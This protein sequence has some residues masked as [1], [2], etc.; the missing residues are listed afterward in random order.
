MSL[1]TFTFALLAHLSKGVQRRLWLW[2]LVATEASRPHP[3]RCNL[4]ASNGPRLSASYGF[5]RANQ[6]LRACLALALPTLLFPASSQALSPTPSIRAE[7]VVLDRQDDASVE[8]AQQMPVV[9]SATPAQAGTLTFTFTDDGSTTT[10]TA[11]G[12]LDLSAFTYDPFDNVAGI[13]GILLNNDLNIWSIEPPHSNAARRYNAVNLSTTGSDSYTGKSNLSL[14]GRNYSSDFHIRFRVGGTYY[15]RL[16]AGRFN[17]DVYQV[18]NATATF[19]GTLLDTLG[20]N[21]FHVEH[22]FGSQ[23]IV[24]KATPPQPTAPTGL[25]ATAGDGTVTLNWTD[26]SNDTISKYQLR[27]GQ[28]ATVPDSAAWGDI[29]GSGAT[30]T[31][32][33]VT[34]LTNGQQYAFQIRAVNNGGDGDASATATATPEPDTTPGFGTGTIADQTY[35]QNAAIATLT[36]PE[37]TG[38]NGTLTYS[39][40]PTAPA[41]LAFDATNRTLTGTP[42]AVQSA[43]AYTYTVTDGDGDTATLAFNIT[44]EAPRT[45]TFT[46]SD[47][48]TTTTIAASGSLNMS[49]FRE[50]GDTVP[51][52]IIYIKIDDTEDWAFHPSSLNSTPS[53]R[54]DQLP[55]FNMTGKDSFDGNTEVAGLSNYS[56]DFTIRFNTFR[57]YMIVDKASLTGDIYDPTGKDVT[58]SGTLLSTVGDN[59]FDIELAVGNQK[60]IYKTATPATVPAAPTD[61]EAA[62][63]DTQVDLT[64][65]KPSNSTITK[66]QLRHK[67]GTSFS[68]GDDSLWTDIASSGASTTSHTVTGLTNGTEYAFEIRAVN[69][70]GNSSASS[71]VT[72][73]PTLAVPAAP[74]GLGA[75]AGATK[76]TLM[77]TNPQNTSITK[78]QLRYGAGTTVPAS[79]TWGDIADSGATTT[80]HE[81]TGLTNGTQY[82]FEIRA[83]N[84]TGNSDASATVTAT[85]TVPR[86]LT[87]IFSDDG[88]TVTVDASGS[89]DVSGFNLRSTTN[90]NA[91]AVIKMGDLSDWTLFPSSRLAI[92]IYNNLPKISTTGESSY[93]EGKSEVE[94]LAS[95][96][97]GFH[98]ALDT[99]PQFADLELNSSH[100]SENNIYSLD[101]DITFTGT[102]LTTLEDND[103][104]IEHA[105]GNQKI[106]YTTTPPPAPAA[107]T[108]LSAAA[109][110]TQATLSWTDSN[111]P[112]ITKYQLR[113]GAGSTVPA[114]ATWEDITGSGVGTTSHVVTGLTN[115]TQYAFEI[116]TVNAGGDSDASSTATA[117]PALAA[118]AAPTDLSATAGNAQ[119]ALSWTLPTNASVIGDV[120]VR[121]KA[122]ADL[123]FNDASDTWTDLSDGTATTYTATGLTNGTGYTFEVRATNT[124][125]DGAAATATATPALPIAPSAPTGLA[126]TADDTKV[127][128]AWT[129]PQ[130]STIT[131]YQLRYGATEPDSVT[132]P[133]TATWGDIADSG[134]TTTSHVVTGLTNGTEYA[135]E[136]R[137]VNATGDSDASATVTATPSQ[138]RTLTYTFSDNGGT[139]TIAASGSLDV[140]GFT[141]DEEGTPTDYTNIRMDDTDIWGIHPPGEIKIYRYNSLPNF[142]ATGEDTYDG[143][144]ELAGMSNYSSNFHIRFSTWD[145]QLQLDKANFT[146]NIYQISNGVATFS[147]TLAD[148]LGD[149]DFHIEHAIG[150][151]KIIFTATPS[152]TAPDAPTGLAAAAGD[153]EVTLSWD[154]PSNSTI[155]KYQLRHKAGTSFSDGDDSLWTDIAGSGA[156]TTSHTVSGLTNGT[157]YAFEIRA[158]NAGGTGPA[159]EQVVMR[160]GPPLQPSGF[161]VVGGN[162]QVTLSWSD[163]PSDT[164]ITKYQ[165]RHKV[166][167][168]FSDSDTWSDMANSGPTTTTHAVSGLTNGTTWA[169]QI[170]ALNAGG[171]G[172]ASETLTML[173][174]ANNR[175]PVFQG[176]VFGNNG[177]VLPSRYRNTRLTKGFSPAFSDPDGDELTFTWT[178]N[179]PQANLDV[180]ITEPGF[181]T[182]NP[183]SQ[184]LR[185]RATGPVERTTLTLTGTD[186]YGLSASTSAVVTTSNTAPKAKSPPYPDQTLA[187]GNT[188]TVNMTDMFVDDEGDNISLFLRTP[189]SGKNVDT[190]AAD[191]S[192]FSVIAHTPGEEVISVSV[193]DLFG[194][195]GSDSFKVTVIAAA[196][197]PAGL[198]ATSGDEQ[199]VLTWINPGDSGITKYQVRHKA[200]TSFSE[201]DDGLWTDITGSGASTTSHTVTGLTSG[202]AYVFQVRA[203]NAGGVGT[204]S[205]EA[206]L[207]L[208]A[209]LQPSGF[210]VLGGNAE[211]TL[212]WSD[213]SDA[214][215]TRYQLRRKVGTSFSPSDDSLWTDMANSGAATTTHTVS[216]LT[217]NTTWAFQVRAVNANGAG[218]ASETLTMLPR[219]NN[220]APVLGGS[221]F[222][223]DG[224]VLPSRYRN[225][226]LTKGFGPRFLDPDGDEL[227]FTWTA[228]PPQ[229]NLDVLIAEPGYSDAYPD[230]HYLRYRATGPVERTTL[231]LTGTDPYGLSV[232]TSAVVTTSNTAP[233]AK[234][235]PYPDQILAVGNTL[236][237]KLTDMFV[238]EDGDNIRSYLRTPSRGESI[239]TLAVDSGFS[240]TAHT[241]GEDDITITVTDI[242]NAQ[243]SDSFKVTVI[244]AA[245]K[246]TGFTATSGDEQAVLAWT[247]PGDSSITKYQLRHK[248]G[249]SFSDSDD[250]LWADIDGSGAGTT[251][252]TVTEL[253]NGT[254]YVFQ[255]RAVN[256]GGPGAASDTA[257]ATPTLAIPDT[258]PSLSATK[259]D[260]ETTLT[261]TLPS[262]ASQIDKVQVRWKATADMP[263]GASDAWT[264][265]AATAETYTATGLTN[266]TSYTFAVRA[267]NSAGNGAAATTTAT[268]KQ[269]TPTSANFTLEVSKPRERLP[270]SQTSSSSVFSYT[271]SVSSGAAFQAVQIVALPLP[272]TGTLKTIPATRS[273]TAKETDVAAGDKISVI[274]LQDAA[275]A[276]ELAFFPPD[277][278]TNFKT[279]FTFKV[280]DTGDVVS[281]ETYTATLDFKGTTTNSRPQLNIPTVAKQVFTAGRAVD[282]P[283]L[284]SNTGNGKLKYTMTPA[285]PTGLVYDGDGPDNE[286]VERGHAN[287]PRFTG[288]PMQVTEEKE[289]TLTVSDTDNE[290]GEADEDTV[291]FKIEVV[292]STPPTASNN[293][294]TTDED[295]AYTFDAADFNFSDKDTGDTFA[296]VKITSLATAGTLQLSDADVIQDQEITVADIDADKLTFTPAANEN[297]TDYATFQFTV[298]DS[299]VDSE[300]SY[301]MTIDVTA[302]NDAPT[303]ASGIPDRTAT[304]GS[305]FSYTFPANTFV[306]V[307]GDTL[308][309]TA[310]QSDDSALPSWLS[311]DEATRTFS[312]TPQ[313]ADVDTVTTVKVTASDG[314]DAEISDE[315]DVTVK[316]TPNT[317][318]TATDSMVTTDEDTTYAFKA[319]DFNFSDV[320][321]GDVLSSV[322]VTVL[323][324]AGALKLNGADVT[325]GQVIAKAALDAGNLAFTPAAHENGTGYATFKFTVNDGAADS[326]SSYTMTINVTAVNDVPTAS[327]KTVTTHEDTTYTFA[328]ADFSFSDVDT[329]NTFAS[330]KITELESA[331]SLQLNGADVIL[332]QVIVVADITANN[333]TFTP[334][335]NANGA[336]YSIFKFTV[337]DGTTD[338]ALSY[339]M[340]INVTAVSDAPTAENNTVTTNEDTAYTFAVADFNY[341]DVDTGQTLASVKITELETA[342]ALQLD[343]ADVTLNQ[344]IIA[345]DIEADKLTFT[346]AV[347]ANGDPYAT[348][349]FT[350]NDGTADSVLPYTMTIDVTAVNDV[351]TASDNTV[352]TDEDTTHTF[353]VADFNYNDVETGDAL[354]SVKIT[355]LETAGALQLSGADVTLD[356]VIAAADIGEE[357]LTFAPAA[358]A[359][360]APYATFK[361][362]VNDGAA[363]SALPYTMTINVTA[364]NDAPTAEDNKV[365]TDEDKTYTFDAADFKFRD[366]D[367]GQTLTSVT[368]T[369]LE[370]AGALQLSGAGVTQDQVITAADIEADKLTFTPASNANG[371]PYATFNFTVNDGTVDSA[372][373]YTMTI[374]VTA[375]NDAPT[376]VNGIP[377]RTA[378]VGSAF[379]YAFPKNTFADADDT[380]TYTATQANGDPLPSWMGFTAA[381]RLFSGTPATA[382]LGTVSVKVTANDGNGGEISDEFDVTVRATPNTP[383][384]AQDSMVTTDE[385]TAYV[386]KASDFNFS[387]NDTGDVL[388]S[389]KVTALQSAAGVLKLNGVDVTE[390]RVIAKDALDSGHLTFTPAA[391]ENGTGYATFQF[392]VND[393]EA[394]SASSYT[395]K[396]DV[397]AVNDAPAAAD[398]TVT[399]NEGTAYTFAVADFSFSDDDTGDALASVKITELESAGS[400]QLNDEDVTLDQVIEVADIIAS[401]LTF[402]PAANANGTNYATFKFTVNDGAVD[403]ASSYTMTINVTAVND[404]PT[405]ENNTVTTDE[406]KTY[407]FD[408]ADFKFSDVDTGGVLASVKITGLATAGALQLGNE[409]VTLDQV[410]AVADIT[411]GN[412]KFT[413]ESDANGDPYATFK[414]TVN[415][416]T[417]DSVSSY[418][419]TI[420]VTAVNDVPTVAN[421]IPDQPATVAGAFRYTFPEKTFADADGD[422]LTYTATQANGDPLPSWMG[423]TAA[424]R[425]FL[426]V[427]QASNLGTVALRVTA[428]DGNGGTVSDDFVVTV[429]DAP[430]VIITA[431]DELTAGETATVTVTF[432]KSVTGFEI[433]EL[434][435]T[436]ATAGTLSKL[437]FPNSGTTY[438]AMLTLANDAPSTIRLS[439]ASDVAVD[440]ANTGNPGHITQE[441]PIKRTGNVQTPDTTRPT[442]TIKTSD[443]ELTAGETA[444]VT[445][446]FS[447]DVTGFEKGDLTASAGSLSGFTGDGTTYTATLTPPDDDKGTITLSVAAGVAKD[448]AGNVNTAA[449]VVTLSYNTT[450]AMASQESLEKVN[451]V[452]LPDIIHNTVG[453]HV[454]VL[455]AR[456][457]S[458]S[459]LT[460]GRFGSS[461]SMDLEDMTNAI[462]S[463]VFDYGDELANGTVD[464]HQ[465]LDGRSFSFPAAATSNARV[466]KGPEGVMDDPNLGLFSTLSF[467]GRADYSSFSRELD[468]NNLQ[469]DTEGDTFT[470]HIGADVQPTPRLATGLSLA[471]SR[472][473]VDWDGKDGVNGTHTVNFTTVH[474]YVSWFAGNWQVWISGLFGSG[475]AEW[476][477]EEGGVVENS[478]SVSGLA[479]GARYRFWKSAAEEYPPS[480]SLKLD[481]ATASFLGVDAL[482]ARLAIEAD[483]QFPV[484]SGE[485]TGA[486]S[487]GLRIKD[488]STYGTGTAVEVGAGSTWQGERLAVSGQGRLLFGVGEQE[489]REW[490]VSGTV[491]YTPGSDGEGVMVSLEPSI[492]VTSSKQAELWNLTGSDLALGGEQEELE[493]RLRAELAYGLRR[494]T[495]LLTP[496]TELS[497]TPS[498]NIYGIG[499]RYDLG[500]DVMLDLHGSHT[501]PV[502]G[503]GENS[504]EVDLNTQF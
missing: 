334:E 317:P 319:S 404:A 19:T 170:R 379:S 211:V 190:S 193:R 2:V 267:I 271:P 333:L 332:D 254:D 363:D 35:T 164:T 134:A 308:T 500:S 201:G 152:I 455:T 110:D 108:G 47:D 456:F 51:E 374:D 212:S 380:L 34:G 295:T 324:S 192:A 405:A 187:V 174:R 272:G 43:T 114:S 394:D 72:A 496:Y 143:T 321:T 304:V 448:S 27:Y 184:Y 287:A 255:I 387:D 173:P 231:I 126:A 364:V 449:E 76:V 483:R 199:A 349:K 185:Y 486:A 63:G 343:G 384:T 323:E 457:D 407:T 406:D 427:P 123:P 487:L 258:P 501:A 220:R 154:N 504:L 175:A 318:P 44:I 351:P 145:K 41:G 153:T 160:P 490:G 107:P 24:F 129:N 484:W 429:T 206:V 80:S 466:I 465:A 118:P 468:H 353:D 280:I 446:T 442:A 68:D 6:G 217:N 204:P 411:A 4:A 373:S 433:H 299:T 301:T 472:S 268:P 157:Q 309:Y 312:G 75:T 142:V 55:D 130:D 84:A 102:L 277:G 279:T 12:S 146:G 350:V 200:G 439:V 370:T 20:D 195:E 366:V 388:S 156:G 339:T 476:D 97:S 341:S 430:T 218:P 228:N 403:S 224:V 215:I 357:K 52:D 250:S 196:A 408:A 419:M 79:A 90:Q 150:N 447:E 95:Y 83:V 291:T 368:I 420:D 105:I 415:D 168:S 499:V 69:D 473:H 32:H 22:A 494:G 264:D 475:D 497:I 60:I 470:V 241:P 165:L 176:S 246:P 227:T 120:Q 381:T 208:G 163:P 56:N 209:P 3:L 340:T 346:P 498:S 125:G 96:N 298:S 260:T 197:K 101:Q 480:L 141:F 396:I 136:I 462:A 167:T 313:A 451:T 284:W 207:R 180:L 302:V 25:A 305:A 74:T 240:V 489:W 73:T 225:V 294:V 177:V 104:H 269:A 202:T 221:V 140:S 46:F 62:V 5:S 31:S 229:A 100:I 71:T 375:V 316:A 495:V 89:L 435:V 194:A 222:G 139:V 119:A 64:W 266:D 70:R 437:D 77:W 417:A 362:T 116:R 326:A 247:D 178:A 303:M 171:A 376:L 338:S 203:V 410:I 288:M 29:D 242:F 103:F 412:L 453:H 367:T 395:M 310:T 94:N 331:G 262:N 336:P 482:Q 36:L 452:V 147:G 230:S 233:K 471:F 257:T 360:G 234:S 460:L 354:A 330:V 372:A 335:A 428:D 186:P 59:D 61:L 401:N 235:P 238:D 93:N 58:F 390:G 48:G 87:F 179:P 371:D 42:T 67:A 283:F 91:R 289:Y 454:E 252:H 111:D 270:A 66:Y 113:Y 239:S 320:D 352:T 322:K 149:N 213:P 26:P 281:E 109:G 286:G 248:A 377:D 263:F 265:L 124:A 488:D 243:G 188:L 342:G 361:F 191:L 421:T 469:A 30:T 329:G 275:V 106:V 479:G 253:T 166:G 122:T 135:F 99:D 7:K 386:F 183:D 327:D 161:R 445:V 205:D 158:V 219:A 274:S 467:W 402:M 38:G 256:A 397:A 182:V 416:G 503:E 245:A 244:A 359:N 400:L 463:T 314:N 425:T 88:S 85:P 261:W 78:Y 237:V 344:V 138:P 436:P 86:T 45:L 181:S 369:S 151:Q 249:T 418:T 112:T 328:V 358:N 459:P 458:I 348:F 502:R 325:E 9:L 474:P 382:D 226:R 432:S 23:K 169:F 389:V 81:V 251:G 128:L 40:T 162:A 216:G 392:T 137:A 306:D 278:N 477:P 297:G 189:A 391:N 121:W 481:G 440:S 399:T 461:I 13:Q 378:T 434:K 293:T 282:R 82:A 385:D 300:L 398:N 259:G 28:G 345:A 431:P 485:L 290:T 365:T 413:P 383:P 39:L 441:I 414:F 315:F 426:G 8:V 115:G 21:D 422:T 33:T 355:S 17:D 172:P 223:N 210:R 18:S 11:S 133:T 292:A 214:T 423:F 296:S 92:N 464:W 356:Q 285:L 117:T 131:K 10:I 393:G 54:Y 443:A 132:V 159:S 37:A 478:G 337:N 98:V 53:K 16:D 127:T 438:T 276:K 49:G 444:T 311:F 1:S 155:T 15:L 236:T 307:D 347:N 492:G 14:V 57:K 491:V 148:T 450:I 424:T 198:T 144:P 409:P 50:V 273:S 493:P 232:S 65:T